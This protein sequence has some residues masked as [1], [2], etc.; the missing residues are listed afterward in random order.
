[1]TRDQR[2]AKYSPQYLCKG[3]QVRE[4]LFALFNQAGCQDSVS[5]NLSLSEAKDNSAVFLYR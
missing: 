3:G 2:T 4:Q 5:W 1:M